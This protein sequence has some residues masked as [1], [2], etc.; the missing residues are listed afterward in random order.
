MNQ[1]LHLYEFKLHEDEL[2]DSE[3]VMDEVYL[4][5]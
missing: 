5:F 3:S 2:R 4:D 1:A